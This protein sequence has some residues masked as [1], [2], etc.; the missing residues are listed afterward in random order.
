MTPQTTGGRGIGTWKASDEFEERYGCLPHEAPKRYPDRDPRE[1]YLEWTALLEKHA[2][3]VTRKSL[4]EP[5]PHPIGSRTHKV[6]QLLKGSDTPLSLVEISKRINDTSARVQSS[7]DIL[8]G[9]NEIN[10]IGAKGQGSRCR[11]VYS[12]VEVKQ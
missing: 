3:A 8:A 11:F 9:R 7:L 2:P 1:I 12:A 4:K 6:L 5:K 10:K